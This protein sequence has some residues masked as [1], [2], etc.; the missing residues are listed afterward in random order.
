MHTKRQL[1]AAAL[2]LL[3]SF[4]GARRKPYRDAVGKW[5]IGYG[6]LLSQSELRLQ[7]VR[8]GEVA[9]PFATGLTGAQAEAL[10][11]QDVRWAEGVVNEAVSV[12]LS[13]N[14]FDALVSF[15]FN[16]GAGRLRR[17]ALLR[18]LNKGRYGDVPGQLQ[19]YVR[20]GGRRL[21]GLVIRRAR[22]AELWFCP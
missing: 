8:I 9:V 10:L 22:E 19:R 11:A 2:S 13:Q 16:V 3:R 15:T 4:E 1:S 7:A 14:Q 12:P 20:A 5:T 6:H 21:R 17:S 18:A